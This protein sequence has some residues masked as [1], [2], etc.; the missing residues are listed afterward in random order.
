MGRI[1]DLQLGEFIA[2]YPRWTVDGE[3]MSRTFEF[4]DFSQAF[5][6]VTRVAMLAERLGHHPDVD[7]RWNRVTLVLTTHSEGGLT[8]ADT[9]LAAAIENL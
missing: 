8:T 4:A 2:S 6:F 7:I 3:A 5:G 1:T 9:E